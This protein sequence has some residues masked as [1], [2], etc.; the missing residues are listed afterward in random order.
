MSGFKLIAIRPL[1]G[2][3]DRFSKNLIKGKIYKFYDNY[4]F[5]NANNLKVSKNEDVENIKINKKI[6]SSFYNIKTADNHKIDINISAV[7]GKN[8]SGKSSLIELLYSGIY[9]LSVNEKKLTP[10]LES[11]EFIK[12][13]IQNS[14]EEQISDHYAILDDEKN[15]IFSKLHDFKYLG[16][17][18][19]IYL[20]DLKNNFEQYLDRLDRLEKTKKNIDKGLKNADKSSSEIIKIKEQLQVEIYYEIKNV[21]Y[22]LIIKDGVS[23]IKIINLDRLESQKKV[24]ILR[25]LTVDNLLSNPFNLSDYFFYTISVNYS[26]YGLNSNFLGTWI[27]NLFHKNDGYKTPIVI[28]PMRTKGNYDINDEIKFAKYRLLSNLIIEARNNKEQKEIYIT[29]KQFVKKIRFKVDKNKIKEKK[30]SDSGKNIRGNIN[31]TNLLLDLFAE[32]Y[33]D[34]NQIEIRQSENK[35]IDLISNYLI[36]KVSKISNTYEGFLDGY[37]F[38]STYSPKKNEEFIA[39]L[40]QESSHVTTKLKQALNFLEHNTLSTN[41]KCFGEDLID[42]NNFIEFTLYELIEWMAVPE[43]FDIINHIPPS[44]FDFEI[45]LADKFSLSADAAESNFN[46]LSS[47]EQQMIHSIQSVIYHLNNLQSVNYS[48][49]DRISYNS[50]NIIF[51]EIE[52]YFHPEYQRR[53]IYNLLNSFKK[54]YFGEKKGINSINIQFLTHSPFILSDIPNNNLLKLKKGNST[55]IKKT[56]KTFGANI[57]ELLSHSFFMESTTGEFAIRKVRKIISFYYEVKKSNEKEK[58]I[59]KKKF[60]KN[61]NK[62]IFIIDNIG[63]DLIKSTLK[64]HMEFI[65]ENLLN[66]SNNQ[67]SNEKD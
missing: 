38:S 58:Q 32:F 61:K 54:L 6:P 64:N 39:K 59:L 22:Q 1:I 5:I 48:V 44:I 36:R 7:V 19:E 8:G 2:C 60:I 51:D 66:S 43:P 42:S 15:Q 45:I 67:I 31:N 62:F 49:V 47:G 53:F 46:E 27:T 12:N 41:N 21:I 14:K 3:D 35:F 33:P 26:H 29:D 13:V 57:H 23:S 25:D 17:N 63:E 24:E 65:E 20:G 30:V 9:L 11:L 18:D 37:K 56:E 10:N 52:L 55:S 16:T 34:A 50:I 28:N 4:K 40:K